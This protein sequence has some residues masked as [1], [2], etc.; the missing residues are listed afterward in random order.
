MKRTL[1]TIENAGSNGTRPLDFIVTSE[2]VGHTGFPESV[3]LIIQAYLHYRLEYGYFAHEPGQ[4]HGHVIWTS[5]NDPWPVRFQ[6]GKLILHEG[7]PVE[8][9]WIPCK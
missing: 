6:E 9:R 4:I 3:D 1:Y 8:T 2:N 7:T 5:D